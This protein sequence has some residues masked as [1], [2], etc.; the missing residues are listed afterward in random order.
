MIFNSTKCCEIK[1]TNI[2]K[3]ITIIVAVLALISMNLTAQREANVWYFGSYAG[4]NFNSGEPEPLTDGRINRWE[5]VATFCDSLGNLLF[6]TDGDSVWN[7]VHAPM[8][9][10]FGLLGDANS[11]ESA[12][13]VPYPTKDSLY[14]I[15]T[16]DEEGGE[17]GLCYSV[18][19]IKKNDGLGAIVLKNQQLATPVSEKLTAVKHGNNQDIWVITHGWK[20]DSFFVYLITP[21]GLNTTPQI[22]EI[23]KRHADIGVHGN[24]A[25]GYLRVSPDGS[26]LASALQV[27]Q[28][29]EVFDFDN[30]TGSISNAIAIPLGGGPYG[31]EFS[32]NSQRLYMTSGFKLFQA[33]ISLPDSAGISNSVTEIGV[34][35]TNNFFG[36]VQL[37]TNGKIY[38]AHDDNMALG[39]VNN[40]N[41]LGA[42]C[43]FELYGFDLAGRRCRMGLPDFIQS[44][45]LPPD[46]KYMNSCVGDNTQFYLDNYAGI[47]NVLWNFNDSLSE[48]N[49]SDELTPIH[50]F[51]AAGTYFVELTIWSGGAEYHKDRIIQINSLP[52]V[53]LGNDTTVCSGD[54]VFLDVYSPPCSYL[55]NDNSTEPSKWVDTEGEYIVTLTKKFTFCE[56]SDTFFLAVSPL[57][58]FDLGNDTIFC[59]NDSLQLSVNYPNADFL[60]NNSV[61]A[62]TFCVM[63]TG[64]YVLQLTDSLGCVNWDTISV[65]QVDLPYFS[66]GEDTIIC[67]NTEIVV[68]PSLLGDYVWS[69]SS[70]NSFLKITTDGEYWL[71]LTDSNGC[72]FADTMLVFPKELPTVKLDNDT[73]LCGGEYLVIDLPITDYEY[74]WSDGTTGNYFEISEAGSYILQATNICGADFDTIRVEYEYCGEIDIPNI[75]TPDGD[76][77]NETFFIKGLSFEKWQLL[78]YNR[79]GN[80]MFKSDD[81]DGLWDGKGLTDATYYYILTN[82]KTKQV[83]SGHV[84][85]YRKR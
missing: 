62:D 85:I 4:I 72:S 78:V 53:S 41:G 25:V 20:T 52:E 36:A 44:Y 70:E 28:V 80:L 45:F 65:Q 42:N 82:P 14:F 68:N 57:P 31:V 79:W 54:S 60:W 3:K 66:L 26:R 16:V 47:D 34:S 15:F 83:F 51:S 11:T 13:I 55:W 19:N 67:P 27:S 69:D 56:N 22:C 43:D 46:F 8:E 40:P 35:L 12:I 30:Q 23:G 38:L 64:E 58:D 77:I 1:K 21:D 71:Q 18:V 48:D 2:L 29:F 24:N 84:R 7:A 74:S 32:P 81:Y 33:D 49:F 75:F 9:G 5:G 6:Y 39:V 10:G 61:A 17:N 73:V 63:Q 50:T 59:E 76:G 37:A